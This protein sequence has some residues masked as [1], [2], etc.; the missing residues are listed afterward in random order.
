MSK[1]LDEL[2]FGA[3][4]PHGFS[5]LVSLVGIMGPGNMVVVFAT[6]GDF[7]TACINHQGKVLWCYSCGGSDDDQAS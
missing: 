6:A 3:L 2:I 1:T 7:Y 4:N 5:Y